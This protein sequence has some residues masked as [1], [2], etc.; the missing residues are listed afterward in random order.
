[1]SGGPPA[2]QSVDPAAWDAV[3]RTL[4]PE[5][6]ARWPGPTEYLADVALRFQRWLFGWIEGAVPAWLASEALWLGV[7]YAIAALALIGLAL[8]VVRRLAERGG[9]RRTEPAR[10]VAPIEGPSEPPGP[11]AWHSRFRSAVAGERWRA[12]L[13]ALWWWTATTL[14]PT[15]L[16]PAWTTDEL[17]RR[18]A[19]DGLRRPL[20][21]LDRF[22]FGGVTPDRIALSELEGRLR[23]GLR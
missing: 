3:R 6:S 5:P 17:V 14:A 10:P 18:S 12:A 20:G 22:R 16:S 2:W 9:S 8:Y 7:V 13:E 4:P 23:E 21:D 15:G 19:R 1:M 11:D